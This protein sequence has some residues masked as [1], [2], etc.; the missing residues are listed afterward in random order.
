[1]SRRNQQHSC[2]DNFTINIICINVIVNHIFAEIGKQI[3]SNL[4]PVVTNLIT[5]AIN[6]S[7]ST[8]A[9]GPRVARSG[10]NF[11]INSM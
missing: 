1:M 8:N 11:H 9:A 7:P 10:K 5:D 6:R 3:V 4:L 2:V